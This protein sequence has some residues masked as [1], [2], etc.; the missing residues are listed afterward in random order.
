MTVPAAPRVGDAV[1]G[2]PR[3]RDNHRLIAMIAA[4]LVVVAVAFG[5]LSSR[6]SA[7]PPARAVAHAPIEEAVGPGISLSVSTDVEPVDATVRTDDAEPLRFTL[8]PGESRAFVADVSITIRLSKGATADV[9]V[10]GRD[11]GTPGRSSHP[12][13]R[14]FSYETASDAPPTGA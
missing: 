9:V 3:R 7:P 2:A 4:A 10:S 1:V 8:L 6:N 11:L 13:K 5:I 12:W 14:T